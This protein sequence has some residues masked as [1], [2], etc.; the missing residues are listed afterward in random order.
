MTKRAILYARVSGDDRKNATSSIDSQLDACRAY[1]TARGYSIVGEAFE[2][3]DKHTSGADWL[4]ELDKLLRL[5]PSRTF[6]VLICREVD[7]LAR[8][9]FKQLATE[10]ELENHGVTV[11]YVV[12]QFADS[13][14]GRLLKGL[15]SE[16]AEYER[17][18]INRRTHRGRLDSVK[19]GKVTVGGSN[20]PFGYDLVKE[21]GTRRLVV[22]EDESVIVRL[23]F[24]LYA[25]E[26]YTLYRVCEYLTAHNVAPPGKGAN[27]RRR[28]QQGAWYE[29]TIA[30]ILSCETYTGAWHYGK[31]HRVKNKLT[32]KSHTVKR[33]QEEWLRVDCPAI[34]SADLFDLAQCRKTANKAQLGHQHK[35]FYTLGGMMRCGCCGASIT[36]ASQ[37]GTGKLYRYMCCTAHRRPAYFESRCTNDRV[38]ADILEVTVWGWVKS[39]LMEPVRLR[40]SIEEY[41]QEQLARVRPQVSMLESAVARLADAEER[42]S[43]L[44]E[45]YTKGILSL[46]EL[47]SQKTTL[48]KEIDNLTQTIASLRTEVEPQLLTDAQIE[49]MEAVAESVRASI[50]DIDKDP[51]AQ[52]TL[53]QM[54]NL[55][56][57]YTGNGEEKTVGIT[58][59]LGRETLSPNLHTTDDIQHRCIISVRLELP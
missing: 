9:R 12:G 7:R 16:F 43:R 29:T 25:V 23:I 53:Y 44:I 13:D 59:V 5:A 15:V 21:A 1:C 40:A 37:K 27:H 8:N 19:A 3:P 55:Q 14:E 50:I 57:V 24:H 6:D 52:R 20:A 34:I 36:G 22:N 54:L 33:P 38:R 45:A 18:K 17:K 41:Q 4:P 32:G 42:K 39:V 49:T 51:H 58:C 46:D 48:D 26:G 11:E 30:Y 2:D 28:K 56:A 47:A 10:I 31:Q 35:N